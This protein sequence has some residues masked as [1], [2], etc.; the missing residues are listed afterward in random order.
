MASVLSG[1]ARPPA[2][3]TPAV[4]Q[5]VQ[6][7]TYL[8]V[9][10]ALLIVLFIANAIVQPQFLSQQSWAASMAVLCPIV[11]TAMAM[12]LPILSGNGG[13]DLSVGPLA[14]F[15][16]VLIAAVLVPAGITSP[17]IIPIVIVFGLLSGALNGVL[18]AYVRLPAII[19]TL[20]MYLFYQGLGTEVLPE[21]GGSVPV[22]LVKLDGSFGP[23]PAVWVVFAV[24]AVIW[25]LLTRGSYPRN[26]LSVGGD[27]RAAYTA[28]VNVSRLRVVTYSLAGA[29][30]AIAGLML[31]GL[32][33]GGDG[34]V[35]APYT[36][37]AITAVAL[38]GIALAGGRGGLLGGALGGAVLFLIQELLTD[39]KVS[40]YAVSVVNGIILILALA[41]NG[42]VEYLRRK[43][44]AAKQGQG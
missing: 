6:R 19:A 1:Q 29:L 23:I 15:I 36:I 5:L 42:T 9:P 12:T 33:Q 37:S 4:R 24:I 40:V 3:S 20:G 31:T 14:G 43:S 8:A 32:I 10:L 18:I 26:L 28:G 34:T 7:N 21:A 27:E 35:G 16:T 30:A 11:L 25:L 41:L 44:A 13:I 2:L 39:A 38:G 17:L 22:W